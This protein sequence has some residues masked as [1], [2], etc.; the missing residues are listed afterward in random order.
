V[1]AVASACLRISSLID[2]R[3]VAAV[4]KRRK[5]LNVRYHSG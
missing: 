5:A 2:R 1:I 3:N 4:A